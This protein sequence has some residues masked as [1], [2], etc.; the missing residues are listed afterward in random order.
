MISVNEHKLKMG[1]NFRIDSLNYC[2]YF[3]ERNL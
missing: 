1:M 3:K 2:K